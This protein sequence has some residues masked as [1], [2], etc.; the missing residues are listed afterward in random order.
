MHFVGGIEAGTFQYIS[1]EERLVLIIACQYDL[2]GTSAA[3]RRSLIT[4]LSIAKQDR[5]LSFAE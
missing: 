1:L 2:R 5:H 3:E 4:S